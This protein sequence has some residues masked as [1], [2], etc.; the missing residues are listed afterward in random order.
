MEF[1]QTLFSGSLLWSYLQGWEHVPFQLLERYNIEENPGTDWDKKLPSKR[2]FVLF[3]ISKPL[4]LLEKCQDCFVFPFIHLSLSEIWVC[5]DR[6]EDRVRNRQ[7]SYISEG[8]S[9]ILQHLP[10]LPHVFHPALAEAIKAAALSAHRTLHQPALT[11]RS[12]PTY[13]SSSDFIPSRNV[14]IS[15]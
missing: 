15:Q 8:F 9:E 5:Q 2:A 3:A 11:S 14:A 4:V 12:Q 7:D 6:A 10:V 1:R 13:K